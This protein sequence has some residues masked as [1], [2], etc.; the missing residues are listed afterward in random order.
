MSRPVEYKEK[1]L[2]LLVPNQFYKKVFHVA[3]ICSTI[4]IR[5]YILSKNYAENNFIGV[6]LSVEGC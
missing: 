4:A 3:D 1:E 2:E 5:H 6:Y